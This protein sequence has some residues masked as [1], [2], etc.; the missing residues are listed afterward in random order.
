MSWVLVLLI[1]YIDFIHFSY[2]KSIINDIIVSEC[3]ISM[4]AGEKNISRNTVWF[5]I[6]YLNDLWEGKN[7]R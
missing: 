5:K 3:F 7:S 4:P 1:V 6:T 2:V